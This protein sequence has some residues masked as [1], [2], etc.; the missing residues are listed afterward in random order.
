MC[1][2]SSTLIIICQCFITERVKVFT[3]L[4]FACPKERNKEKDTQKNAALHTCLATPLFWG[5]TAR[6]SFIDGA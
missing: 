5:A 4:S 1:F 2:W 6:L 3:F